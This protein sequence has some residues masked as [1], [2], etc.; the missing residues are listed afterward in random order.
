VRTWVWIIFVSLAGLYL[1]GAGLLL[2][3]EMPTHH[4]ERFGSHNL[5]DTTT[6]RV[7]DMLPGLEN[8]PVQAFIGHQISPPE[9]APK[10]ADG[11]PI[12]QDKNDPLGI[13]VH[14]KNDPSGFGH[15]ADQPKPT[16][17]PCN[18]K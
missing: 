2:G 18:P 12:V 1:F 16:L 4:F 6:G 3:R 10:N 9:S 17:P 13:G 11:L 5:F 7:C 15:L 14:E 8:D